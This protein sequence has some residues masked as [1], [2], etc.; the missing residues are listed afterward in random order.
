MFDVPDKET[1]VLAITRTFVLTYT[2]AM[3]LFAL[4]FCTGCGLVSHSL[5]RINRSLPIS[6]LP[7][8]KSYSPVQTLV[9]SPDAKY[10]IQGQHI[11]EK[12]GE[13]FSGDILQIWNIEKKK[14]TL[15]GRHRAGTHLAATF[16]PDSKYVL[17]C[18]NAGIIRIQMSDDTVEVIPLEEPKYL[19]DDGSLVA[20]LLNDGWVVQTVDTQSQVLALPQNVDRFLAFSRDNKLM[21]TTIKKRNTPGGGSIVALWSLDE[22]GEMDAPTPICEIP[23]PSYFPSAEKTRFSPNSRFL[24]LPSR[25]GGYV[26]I[27]DIQTGK[28][29]KELGV[30]DGSIRTLEFSPD[31]KILAVGTQE[32]SGKYGKIYL[33]EVFSGKLIE[34]EIINENQAKG[35][36]ALGFASDNETIFFGNSSGDVKSEKIKKS[37]SVFSFKS[38]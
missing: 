10:L 21:A 32:A 33:W 17:A 9:I 16:S 22:Q 2:M 12:E 36:T 5:G 1:V 11:T 35:V 14:H 15:I 37:D 20:C 3:L 30:H 26:G 7:N 25:Q 34:R 18:A 19:S 38:R 8:A 28:M 6:P 13:S 23:V 31:G 27:W 4:V 24:A 29:H